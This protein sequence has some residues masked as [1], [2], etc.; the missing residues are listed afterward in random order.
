MFFRI[1][2]P[3]LCLAFFKMEKLF[4]RECFDAE[5]FK[6]AISEDCITDGLQS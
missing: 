4:N 2:D 1:Y 6:T 3:L 5:H